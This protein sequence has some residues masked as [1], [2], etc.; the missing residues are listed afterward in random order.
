MYKRLRVNVKVKRGSTFYDYARPSFHTLSL[1][2]LRA[3][4][5]KNYATVE[6]GLYFTSTPVNIYVGTRARKN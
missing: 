5:R 3:Y 1:S 6:I 4:A 2:Y